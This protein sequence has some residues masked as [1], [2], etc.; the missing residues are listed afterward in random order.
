MYRIWCGIKKRCT[1]K[2]SENFHI[3][4]ER[5]IKVC[6][7][8]KNSYENFEF[9]SLSHGYRDDL[10]IDRI[11]VN[12]DYSPDNCRWATPKEQSNNTRRCIF[13]EYD[14][15]TY[16]IKEL[17][18]HLCINYNKLYR[19]IREKNMSVE[20]AIKYAKTYKPRKDDFNA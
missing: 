9:W 8:W 12:G 15:K 2:N 14:N 17:S 13:I 1:N 10:T 11:D 7:E 19:G 20:E 18:E 5:G 16:S 6:D 4:G 3:Y